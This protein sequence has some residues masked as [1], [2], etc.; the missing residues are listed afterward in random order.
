[1]QSQSSSACEVSPQV[2]LQILLDR[3]GFSPGEID[4]LA[5]SNTRRA[6]IA[7][8]ESKDL[9][10]NGIPNQETLAALEES[11]SELTTTYTITTEDENGPFTKNIPEDEMEKAQLQALNYTSEQELLGE[12]FHVSPDVL[13]SM[14]PDSTFEAGDQI[15]VPDVLTESNSAESAGRNITII[16]SEKSSDLVVKNADGQIL[17]YAPVTAG[18]EH[19][20]LPE[21]TW[22]VTRVTKNPTFYYNPDL[23]WEA[24]AS[25]SKATIRPGPNNPVG[26][27]WIGLTAKHYGIHGTPEPGKIGHSESNG[28]VR[29]T[30]WDIVR[31]AKYVKPGTQ[32]IFNDAKKMA[33]R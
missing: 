5:G 24:D 23:F 27:I 30:N 17:F 28:C 15:C 33:K 14:N 20:P 32:V 7:F 16:V 3:A 10:A 6:L 18:S 25:H 22:K 29:L 12:K 4:G 1:M 9:K 19:D 11:Q 26:I 2:K 13:R 21:G 31:V 8:Q